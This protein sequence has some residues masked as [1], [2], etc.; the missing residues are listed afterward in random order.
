[1]RGITT[2]M[3]TKAGC[4]ELP[5]NL[6][7]QLQAGKTLSEN[8]IFCTG[9]TETCIVVELP[10]QGPAHSRLPSTHHPPN[11]APRTEL[12]LTSCTTGPADPVCSLAA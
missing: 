9:S 1:M 11:S 7:T 12:S 2:D 6:D 4:L 8:P 3:D 10:G 5:D